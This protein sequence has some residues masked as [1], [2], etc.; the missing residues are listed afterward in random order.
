MQAESLDDPSESYMDDLI[1]HRRRTGLRGFRSN[2]LVRR[3]LRRRPEALLTQGQVGEIQA[4]DGI[5][6]LDGDGQQSTLTVGPPG[7]ILDSFTRTLVSPAGK[8]RH[9]RRGSSPFFQVCNDWPHPDPRPAARFE[10]GSNTLAGHRQIRQSRKSE[11]IRCKR[12]KAAL[13][14][15]TE[16]PFA[17][18]RLSFRFLPLLPDNDKPKPPLLLIGPVPLFPNP[19]F[20]NSCFRPFVLS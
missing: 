5:N 15:P 8:D 10:P 6:A 1:P 9:G 4:V 12:V 20:P 16:K 17:L 14:P 3:D 19:L 11:S 13:G 2:V 18:R 7:N